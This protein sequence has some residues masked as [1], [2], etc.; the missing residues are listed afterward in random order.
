MEAENEAEKIK[1]SWTELTEMEPFSSTDA[2]KNRTFC[3]MCGDD[4]RLLQETK[5]QKKIH[6]NLLNFNHL[7]LSNA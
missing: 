3:I 2:D 7:L 5:H 4:R 1:N 6:N